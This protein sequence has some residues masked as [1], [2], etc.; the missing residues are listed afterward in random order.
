MAGLLRVDRDALVYPTPALACM[1][2]LLFAPLTAAMDRSRV[3]DVDMACTRTDRHAG[4]K[5]RKGVCLQPGLFVLACLIA[6]SAAA[7]DGIRRC[8]GASGEPVFSDRPCTPAPV[9]EHEAAGDHGGPVLPLT[10]TCPTSPRDLRDRVATAF[11]AR[12]AVA[13]SGLM[14]WD[15]YGRSDATTTLRE[16]ARL[17]E[18]PLLTLELERMPS[19]P[20]ADPYARPRRSGEGFDTLL[21][22]RTVRALD[23]VPQEARTIFELVDQ[24]GCWWLRLADW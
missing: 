9:R 7:Q 5:R 2:P 12:N 16:L 10:Q 14:L 15:G 17:V 4:G 20:Y 18:E 1:R 11:D 19:S 13:L 24:R 23:R 6:A 21:T 22:A 8:I 3:A